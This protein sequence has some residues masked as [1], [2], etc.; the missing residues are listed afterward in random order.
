VAVAD[1]DL[2]VRAEQRLADYE[3]RKLPGQEP[4]YITPPPVA[5][6]FENAR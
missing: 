6:S 1:G 4:P 3:A 2:L 5:P